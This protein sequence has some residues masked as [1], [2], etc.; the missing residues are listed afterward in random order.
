MLH[1]KSV[2]LGKDRLK[3]IREILV[4]N[5]KDRIR[6]FENML[7]SAASVHLHC[8]VNV[9]SSYGGLRIAY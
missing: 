5:T 1:T 6:P 8:T 3:M 7:A 4:G 2:K 9:Y